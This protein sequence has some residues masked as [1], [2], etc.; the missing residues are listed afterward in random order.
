MFDQHDLQFQ[1][2]LQRIEQFIVEAERDANPIVL[3][4]TKELVQTLLDL[5][6]AGLARIIETVTSSGEP[7]QAILEGLAQDELVKPLLVLYGL[8]PLP[9]EERVQQAVEK[10]RPS[11]G[12]QGTL[13]EILSIEE[14]RVK[15]NVHTNGHG[16]GHGPASEALRQALEEAIHEGA[17]DVVEIEILGLEKAAAVWSGFIPLAQVKGI[18]TDKH[19]REQMAG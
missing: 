6:S 8:H 15:L 16:N 12:V 4:K 7:G 19:G 18:R 3:E 5:H 17:P 10:A 14:R 9:F 11:L 13:V 1:Q 2:D